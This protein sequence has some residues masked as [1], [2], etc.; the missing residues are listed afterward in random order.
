MLN[1]LTEHDFQDEFKNWQKRSDWSIRTEGAYFQGDSGKWAQS[2]Y[3]IGDSTSPL[4]YRYNLL[5]TKVHKQGKVNDWS[6]CSYK[7]ERKKNSV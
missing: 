2:Q 3:F 1:V 6:G 7:C 4:N 5:I